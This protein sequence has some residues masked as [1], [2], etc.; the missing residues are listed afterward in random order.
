MLVTKQLKLTATNTTFHILKRFLNVTVSTLSLLSIC[1][2]S[3]SASES[4]NLSDIQNNQLYQA[5]FFDQYLPQNALDMVKRLPGFKYDKGEDNRGF[6]GNAGNVLVDGVRPTSKSGGLS[7]A[8][9]RI[10]AAQVDYIEILRGGIGAGEASGQSIVANVIRKKEGTN[11]TWAAKLRRAPHG[12]TQP[13]IEAAISTR[14]GDW[15]TAFDTDFGSGP[16]YRTALIEERDSA[17]NLTSSADE[18]LDDTAR[19]L[20]ANGE[21]AINTDKGTLTINARVGAD[22]VKV[23]I[24]REIYQGRQPDETDND[25]FFSIDERRKFKMAELGIDWVGKTDDWK[26]HLIGLGLIND[27][28]YQNQ[29]EYQNYIVP[30]NQQSNFNQDSKKT[31]FI[32]RATYGYAGRNIFKPE[33]GVELAQN[34][35]T[36]DANYRENGIT[37]AL[38]GA[39]VEVEE[40]RTELFATLVY[41]HNDTLTI[42]GGLTGEFSQIEVSGEVTNKQ[43]FQ[44]LKPR[45]SATYKLDTVS[46]IALVAERNV[47]QLDFGDFAASNQA[48]DGNI[49][50]GNPDL[51]PDISDEL[52]ATYDLSF[53]KKGSLTVKLF[54][55]WKQDI[56]EQ[57]VLPSGGNGI[58]NAGEA[59][60]WGVH[61]DVNL[62]L[63]GILQNGLIEISHRY[64]DSDFEDP[65][66]GAK[67]AISDYTPHFLDLKLRQDIVEEKISWGIEYSGSFTDEFFNVDE[68][69]T[70]SGNKRLHAFIETSRY[71]GVKMQLEIKNINTG[72]F[73]RSRYLFNEDR[74]NE[75]E[76]SQVAF[77]HRRP[78]IKFSMWGTF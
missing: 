15:E 59:R 39:N 28:N 20:F 3:V 51:A 50:S 38:N 1:C 26:L 42:E 8:L 29:V 64:R 40:L 12:N 33:Y 24:T 55:E 34:K 58:G 5:S 71:F 52:S 13:N 10:P 48:Q 36:S 27:R 43:T 77:R 45:L 73:T 66:I 2:L 78:E 72:D 31:E 69:I 6:G 56:L 70:F 62:P 30:D 9:N 19:W 21:G 41:Q 49:I 35:L 65:I 11:G 7:G 57:I 53:S 74:A 16:G 68:R 60:F 37:V 14:I 46:Q 18:V 22:K 75:P 61:T 17:G 76:G 32:T 54:H 23:G 47:G 67:R 25:E 4:N 44:F 63:D